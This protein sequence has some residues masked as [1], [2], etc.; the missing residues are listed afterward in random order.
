MEKI[1]KWEKRMKEIEDKIENVMGD[2]ID[3]EL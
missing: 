1:E 3:E 2:G